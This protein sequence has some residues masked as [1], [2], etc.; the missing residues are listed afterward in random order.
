MLYKA[1][2]QKTRDYL[3]AK[4]TVSQ[5][6]AFSPETPYPKKIQHT[7]APFPVDGSMSQTLTFNHTPAKHTQLF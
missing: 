1:V 7:L 5:L 3:P 4:H 2:V 6:F